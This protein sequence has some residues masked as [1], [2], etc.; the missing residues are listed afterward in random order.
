MPEF[1]ISKPFEVEVGDQTHT[2]AYGPYFSPGHD[3][4]SP[5]PYATDA[6]NKSYQQNYITFLVS[7]SRVINHDSPFRPEYDGDRT[8]YFDFVL[9]TALKRTA[10]TLKVRFQNMCRG[11]DRSDEPA[12]FDELMEVVERMQVNTSLLCK[13]SDCVTTK[14]HTINKQSVELLGL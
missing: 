8:D 1:P 11:R 2:M 13:R 10:E 6:G 4:S 9:K 12:E 5:F 7:N 14:A 3:A